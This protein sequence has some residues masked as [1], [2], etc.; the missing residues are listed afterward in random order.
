M[1]FLP[2][3]LVGAAL[4]SCFATTLGIADLNEI[5]RI[6]LACPVHKF[7]SPDEEVAMA[8]HWPSKQATVNTR[9]F[10]YREPAYIFVA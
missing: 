5:E 3:E 8:I 9:L 6:V 4:A 7:L 1:I 10:G 2:T